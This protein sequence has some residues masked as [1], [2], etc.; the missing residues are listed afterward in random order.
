MGSANWADDYNSEVNPNHYR[1]LGLE[2]MGPVMKDLSL[3]FAASW[4]R[5]KGQPFSTEDLPASTEEL[6]S[7]AWIDLRPG[8]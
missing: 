6:P 5:A 8:N 2:L 3:D 7:Q 1:D 4:T